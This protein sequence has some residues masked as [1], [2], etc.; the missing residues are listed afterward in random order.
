ML[1]CNQIMSFRG[2]AKMI[3]KIT[4]AVVCFL[5][6]ILG[7][8]WW[9]SLNAPRFYKINKEAKLKQPL[10]IKSNAITIN[11]CAETESKIGEVFLGKA[12]VNALKLS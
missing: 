12:L 2:F 1:H 9:N 6:I 3:K 8:V 7:T 11:N 10:S 5:L 4:G